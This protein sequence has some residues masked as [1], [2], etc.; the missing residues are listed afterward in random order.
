MKWLVRLTSAANRDLVR[1]A[2]T[3]GERSPVAGEQALGELQRVIASLED[4]PERGFA[5][6]T[7]ALRQVVVPFGR[8]GYVIRYRAS[9]GVVTIS[10]IF[11]GRERR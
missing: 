7:P 9:R 6:P 4:M 11:H 1:L 5:G 10:R 8:D 2:A 3:L